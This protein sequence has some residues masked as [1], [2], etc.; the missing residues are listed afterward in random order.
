[1]TGWARLAEGPRWGGVIFGHDEYVDLTTLA[2]RDALVGFSVPCRPA[3]RASYAPLASR[4]Q[5][6]RRISSDGL[7][8]LIR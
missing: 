3:D 8:G 4:S 7:N 5:R 2:P 6:T 1:V